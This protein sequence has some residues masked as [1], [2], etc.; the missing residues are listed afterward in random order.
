[1]FAGKLNK[2]SIFLMLLSIVMIFIIFSLGYFNIIS[3]MFDSDDVSNI[4]RY[5]Q[6]YELL[7]DLSIEGQGLGAVIPG[8]YNRNQ[9]LPYGFELSYIN[10]LHKLG[11]VGIIVL[12]LYLNT[13]ILIYRNIKRGEYLYSALALGCVCYLFPG[14]GNPVVFA[15]NCVVLHCFALYLLRVNDTRCVQEKIVS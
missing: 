4:E 10:I 11:I 15:P 12:F 6:L 8:G 7:S 3:E 14:I 1:M 9:N 13:F 2:K 5:A